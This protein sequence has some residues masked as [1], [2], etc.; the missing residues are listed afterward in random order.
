MSGSLLFEKKK[1]SLLEVCAHLGYQTVKSANTLVP[2]MIAQH[3]ALFLPPS[4]KQHAIE[5]F[6]KTC[7]EIALQNTHIENSDLSMQINRHL[8]KKSF[9][10][11][12][13]DFLG[14]FDFS[15]LA[16][17]HDIHLIMIRDSFEENPIV[18]GEGEFIDPESGESA[19]FYFG[20]RA[21]DAYATRYQENDARLIKHLHR[22]GI[23]YEKVLS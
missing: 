6:V 21:R 3:E 7:D 1:E 5:H 16:K 8:N 15:V 9:V 4:K 10:I 19:T 17:R 13:G 23:S 18:L 14:D 2:I 20:E 22:L 11:L 12:V